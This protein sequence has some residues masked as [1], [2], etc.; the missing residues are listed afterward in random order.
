MNGKRRWSWPALMLLLI[1]AIALAAA[2]CGGSDEGETTGGAAATGPTETSGGEPITV[3]LVTDIGGLNDRGFNSLA[4][5]GL[6]NA[7]SQ[8]GVQG[9]VLE[10]KS[11]ADYIPNLSEFGQKQSNLVVSVGFLMTD[12]TAKAAK[13]FPDSNFAIVDSA[14]DPALPNA[15]GLLFKEQ[16]AGCLV[17]VVG[18]LMSKSG[19]ITWVG[20]QKIPPVDRFIA[21]YEFCAKDANPDIKVSGS[22]SDDFVDQAKCKEI[23]LDQISKGSDVVFQVAGGCGLGALDA[24]KQESVWG[25]GVDADQSF[26]GD[27]I[28]TS[29]V[30]RVDVA[31]F[32]TIEAVQNG[33]FQGGGVTTFGLAEDGVGLGKVS[34]EVGQDVLDKAEEYKQKILNGEI[35]IPD[36]VS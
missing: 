24:A 18:A 36:T 13:A 34:P 2:G 22:Y 21:G 15:Q 7:E 35:D 10:S 29:A 19:T 30:K 20:G 4:N 16:E 28:L 3:G 23:A 9:D 5:Q 26:L 8:L 12:A 25:I 33:T 1:A 31:V 6:E 17:G 32:K 11:D 27:H 14:F